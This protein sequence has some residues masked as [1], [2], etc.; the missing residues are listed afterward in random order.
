MTETLEQISRI[1]DTLEP[2][3]DATPGEP[4]RADEWNAVVTSV[5]D[6]ARIALS[7]ERTVDEALSARFAPADHVHQGAVGLDWLDP[8]SR[9][10]VEGGRT[11]RAD[12]V[13]ELQRTR[14]DLDAL[15][16]ETATLRDRVAGLERRVTT[17]DDRDFDR[18]QRLDRLGGAVDVI[19]ETETSLADLRRTFASVDD[20]VGEALA[21][22]DELVDADGQRIDLDQLRRQVGELADVREQLRTA[23]GSVVEIRAFEQR[24]ARV[25]TQVESPGGGGGGPSIDLDRFRDE[26]LAEADVRI[27]GQLEPVTA[28]VGRLG[29]RV[30]TVATQV[31]RVSAQA[32]E[33]DAGI[34]VLRST[35]AGLPALTTQVT[36]TSSRVTEQQRRHDALVDLP[37]RVTGV[38]NGLER[39]D[40]LPG[41]VAGLETGLAGMQTTVGRLPQ[42]E[43]QVASLAGL[44]RDV[45]DLSA[46]VD[47]TSQTAQRALVLAQRQDPRLDALEA[48]ISDQRTR[49][50]Q[51]ESASRSHSETL[52]RLAGRPID[53]RIVIDP[54][55]PQ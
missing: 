29:E 52:R 55:R 35:T 43:Q 12:L 54:L 20:R 13:A 36:A 1:V 48:G 31:D 33:L 18:S 30:D 47:A 45:V 14:R 17:L 34:A 22:R 28:D 3:G 19:G 27:Q 25:E 4:V 32:T 16:S 49:L 40:P 38:E 21:L 7:R 50:V 26:V 24:L 11:Q 44:R 2:L 23:D 39:L 53:G 46:R 42:L 41:R 10:L 8:V 9:D 51:I 37:D 5:L 15:R 6:L